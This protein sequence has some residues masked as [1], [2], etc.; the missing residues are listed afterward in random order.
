VFHG[1]TCRRTREVARLV[2]RKPDFALVAVTQQAYEGEVWQAK[3]TGS[4][5]AQAGQ[6]LP[7]VRASLP[8]NGSLVRGGSRRAVRRA[9]EARLYSGHAFGDEE[10]PRGTRLHT[11]VFAF[12]RYLLVAPTMW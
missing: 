1:H 10:P 11:R 6:R 9:Q 4:V 5:Q 7:H 3:L 8:T 12:A 2:A